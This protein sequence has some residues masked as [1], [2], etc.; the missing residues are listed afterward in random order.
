M[1]EGDQWEVVIPAELAYGDQGAGRKIGPNAVLRFD[2][3]LLQVQGGEP[4]AA[5]APAA[6]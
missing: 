5:S 3:E 6:Q 2:M 4:G 1:K